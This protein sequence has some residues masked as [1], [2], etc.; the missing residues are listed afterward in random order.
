M[1]SVSLNPSVTLVRAALAAA[2]L[3]GAGVPG[4]FA[5]DGM[6]AAILGGVAGGVLGGVAANALINGAQPAPPPPPAYRA[7]PVYVEEEAVV[8]R[9]RRSPVCHYERRKEWLDEDNFVY[10]RVEVCE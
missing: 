2:L 9:P 1:S 5:R 10:K 3:I 8:V 7:R 4:A 6:N